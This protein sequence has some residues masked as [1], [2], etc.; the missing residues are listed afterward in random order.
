MDFSFKESSVKKSAIFVLEQKNNWKLGCL[1]MPGRISTHVSPS[2]FPLLLLLIA[3]SRSKLDAAV[4]SSPFF[5]AK[6]R[7]ENGLFAILTSPILRSRG[8]GGRRTMVF[9]A[10]RKKPPFSNDVVFPTFFSLA[11]KMHFLFFQASFYRKK[12]GK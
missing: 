8:E 9:S 10:T 1:Q 7:R 11:Q 6:N 4:A 5:P 3:A 2:F 12:V